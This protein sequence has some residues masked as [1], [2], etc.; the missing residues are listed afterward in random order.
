MP[1]MLVYGSLRKYSKRGYNFNRFGGQH[2]IRRT[3]VKGYEMRDMTYYPGVSPADA[4][5][6]VVAELHE[7]HPVA[8]SAIRNMEKG[9][10]YV[11]HQIKMPE[12]EATLFVSGDNLGQYPVVESGDWN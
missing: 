11:E 1:L 4:S 12:G 3:T 2:F 9:A 7:V 10:G 8:F 6:E 5:K